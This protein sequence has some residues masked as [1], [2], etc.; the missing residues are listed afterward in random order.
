M[1]IFPNVQ[2][3]V[4]VGFVSPIGSCEAERF[5]SVL[6]CVKTNLRATLSEGKLA[7]LTMVAVYYTDALKL[8]TE[9]VV[10]CRLIPDTSLTTQC[11][12]RMVQ[13]NKINVRAVLEWI[14][15]IYVTAI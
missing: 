13:N 15:Y 10:K 4:L 7:G 6:Q 3:L 8:D 2:K 5:F 14:I 9:E 1:D 11:Y 12:L